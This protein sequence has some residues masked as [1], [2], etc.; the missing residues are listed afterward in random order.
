[1]YQPVTR[2]ALAEQLTTI[3]AYRGTELYLQIVLLLD[4]LADVYR[5]DLLTI[6]PEGLRFKQGAAAQVLAIKE[7]LCDVES[8]SQMTCPLP[9]V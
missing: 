9:L 5:N 6:N 7:A 1:M 4:A 2:S 8:G 3:A